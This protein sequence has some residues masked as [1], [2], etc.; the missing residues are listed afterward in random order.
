[1]ATILMVVIV[2]LAIIEY[3]LLNRRA[4]VVSG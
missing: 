3:R 2:A 1:M 4:E